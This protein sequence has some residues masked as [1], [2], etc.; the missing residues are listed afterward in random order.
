MKV[1]QTGFV[2]KAS[3]VQFF[4]GGFDLAT[5]RYSGRPAPRHPG[6][7]PNCPDW[8]MQEAESQQNFTAGWWPRTCGAGVRRSMRMPTR[9]PMG[10]RTAAVVRPAEAYFDARAGE[11][12]LPY[13][14][15][16]ICGRIPTRQLL[17]FL[18]S[19]Y[20]A[21][22]NLGGWDRGALEPAEA[23]DASPT[24][25]VEPGSAASLTGLGG[26]GRAR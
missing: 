26:E 20:E 1:F 9:N 13:D 25:A 16:R 6:G 21:S 11:F 7:V 23:A 8:V 22:A 3:P 19:T 10:F 12:I 5:T 17:E 4:W 18:Q 15:V 24:P 2:G 14:V